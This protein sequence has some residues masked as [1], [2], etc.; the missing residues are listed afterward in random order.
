MPHEN[1]TPFAGSHVPGPAPCF[2][3]PRPGWVFPGAGRG[4]PNRMPIS[5]DQTPALATGGG[6]TLTRVGNGAV[7]GTDAGCCLYG[8]AGCAAVGGGGCWCGGGRCCGVDILSEAIAAAFVMSLTRP[9]SFLP[10]ILPFKDS[11]MCNIFQ[12]TSLI[13]LLPFAVGG[14]TTCNRL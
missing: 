8:E 1:R 12:L 5:G 10:P 3:P 4:P 7:R 9:V 14:Q 6:A 2:G 11:S 13:D